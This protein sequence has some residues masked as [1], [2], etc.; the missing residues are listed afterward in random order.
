MDRALQL[1]TKE[2]QRSKK[3]IYLIFIYL[4]VWWAAKVLQKFLLFKKKSLNM[5][6]KTTTETQGNKTMTENCVK[7]DIRVRSYSKQHFQI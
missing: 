4:E 6:K 7:Q 2:I 1:L 5:I 3:W